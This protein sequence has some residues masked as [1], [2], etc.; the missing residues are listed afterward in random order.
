MLKFAVE[1]NTTSTQKNSQMQKWVFLLSLLIGIGFLTSCEK[2][3]MLGVSEVQSSLENEISTG[4]MDN[5]QS[6]SVTSSSSDNDFVQFPPAIATYIATNYVG[7][8][9]VEAEWEEED[10]MMM[11]YIELSDGTVLVFDEWGTFLNLGENADLDTEDLPASITDYLAMHYPNAGIE[12][13][14]LKANGEYELLL[15]NSLE[16]HFDAEGNFLEVEFNGEK[17]RKQ[18]FPSAVCH[19]PSMTIWMP[20]LQALPSMKPNNTIRELMK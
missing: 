9:V 17:E 8:L 1:N 6:G 16:L 3:Y 15:D 13:A 2:E 7:L 4:L 14:E 11:Y 12:M 5:G 18:L 20:I 10:G 19:K